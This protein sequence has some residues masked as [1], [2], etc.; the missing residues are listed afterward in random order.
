MRKVLITAAILVVASPVMATTVDWFTE[1][2]LSGS[3]YGNNITHTEDGITIT[4]TGWSVAD[5]GSGNFTTTALRR[6]STGLGMCNSGQNPAT[7]NCGTGPHATDNIVRDEVFLLTF[8]SPVLVTEALITAWASDYDASFWGGTGSLNMAAIGL[9]GLGTEFTSEFPGGATAGTSFRPVDLTILGTPVDW[10]VFGVEP[11]EDNDKF[12]FKS[13]SFNVPDEDTPEPGT[14][15][16]LAIGAA[17][18]AARSRK[19]S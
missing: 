10:L 4:V 15:A 14:L 3:G 8:S 5:N 19:Q 2:T 6:W 17:L 11:G 18:L 7:G 16:L 12:K 13:F 9:A 1:G